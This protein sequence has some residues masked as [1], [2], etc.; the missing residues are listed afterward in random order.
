V[1]VSV[2][3]AAGDDDVQAAIAL[4]TE[5]FVAEQGV[6]PEE[7]IDGRD[8]E[9]LHLLAFDE[10]GL[11]GTCRL[12]FGDDGRM[13]LGRMA[14]RRERRGQGIAALLLQRADAEALAAGASR[15][16]LGAQLPAVGVYERAGYE[17][18]GEVFLEAG[19]EH[20]WMEKAVG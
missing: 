3:R 11:V 8:G 5:V 14:V 20:V 2:R 18:R 13:K 12:L 17:R 15:I 6:A 10:G 1:S 16:V 4:R 19:I 7:E 9:A